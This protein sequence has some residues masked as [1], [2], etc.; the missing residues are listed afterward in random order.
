MSG[1]VAGSIAGL[2]WPESYAGYSATSRVARYLIVW[3]SR[4][5]LPTTT[6]LCT[7]LPGQSIV[8]SA[9]SSLRASGRPS[10]WPGRPLVHFRQQ[11]PRREV[12][13]RG[14][15]PAKTAAGAYAGP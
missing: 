11:I 13:H 1:V 9:V 4:V 5:S 7:E 15:H 2:P 6:Q 10:P 8:T 3:L 14:T 12:S